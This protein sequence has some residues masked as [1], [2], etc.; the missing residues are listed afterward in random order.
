MTDV[1]LQTELRETKA[2]LQRLKDRIT[3]GTQAIHKDLSLIALIPK[4][5]GLETGI[6]LEEFLS[7]IEN[8]ANLGLWND[9]D[10]FQIATLRLA[11]T[12]RQFYVGE[13]NENLKY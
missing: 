11:D 5:S 10:K 6:S 4:F 8:T 7:A 13:S 3:A 9:M 2:E 12:A 1:R